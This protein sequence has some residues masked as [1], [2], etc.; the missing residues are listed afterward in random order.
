MSALPRIVSRADSQVNSAQSVTSKKGSL[1]VEMEYAYKTAYKAT[2]KL[3]AIVTNA[4]LS[5]KHAPHGPPDATI[6]TPRKTLCT[7]NS[8][9]LSSTTNALTSAQ[10]VSSIL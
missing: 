7:G 2:S 6:A 10:R 3:K 9:S 1:L 8:F 5:A 4:T